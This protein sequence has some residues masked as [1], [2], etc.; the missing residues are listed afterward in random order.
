[1]SPSTARQTYRDVVAQVAEKARAKLPTAVNGRIESAVK[2]VLMHDVMPQEDGSILVCVFRSKVA[3]D[4]GRT[5]PP[6]PVEGCH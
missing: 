2:L 4:S 1:M 6:I 3:T 5:L